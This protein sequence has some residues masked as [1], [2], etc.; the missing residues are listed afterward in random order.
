[1]SLSKSPL[2]YLRRK[3]LQINGREKR[4]RQLARYQ[5]DNLLSHQRVETEAR[6][7][8]RQWSD[9]HVS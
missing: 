7:W 9:L 4:P 8:V 5:T 2:P 3:R 6:T 1:M